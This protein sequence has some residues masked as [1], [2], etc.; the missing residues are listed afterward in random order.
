[1]NKVDTQALKFN[2]INII[3][4]TVFASVRHMPSLV[5]RVG[6]AMLIGTVRPD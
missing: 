6:P 2:Q 1:M 4:W 5:S 3:G